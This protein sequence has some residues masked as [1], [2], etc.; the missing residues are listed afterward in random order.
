MSDSKKLYEAIRTYNSSVKEL[1]LSASTFEKSVIGA[2]K[3]TVNSEPLK[4]HFDAKNPET[5]DEFDRAILSFFSEVL[6]IAD[7]STTSDKYS[8]TVKEYSN[9]L[10]LMAKG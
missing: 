2:L 10:K 7:R 4:N 8:K 5:Y 6:D 3:R 1:E 9:L